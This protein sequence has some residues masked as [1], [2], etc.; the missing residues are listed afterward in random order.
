MGAGGGRRP[1]SLAVSGGFGGLSMACGGSH[2]HWV[3]AMPSGPWGALGS[4]VHCWDPAVLTPFSGTDSHEPVG[5][6][7]PTLCPGRVT[8]GLYFLAPG[9]P[10][11]MLG[12]GLPF[13]PA[14]GAS[15]VERPR[16][17]SQNGQPAPH[18]A[19]QLPSRTQT[20]SSQPTPPQ[21][22]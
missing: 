21:R 3:P 15:T 10:W 18:E 2:R 17:G 11:Q 14:M 16:A 6:G 20:Q 5:W 1:Q 19:P 22:P 13:P 9:M 8:P 12:A 7:H 4:I